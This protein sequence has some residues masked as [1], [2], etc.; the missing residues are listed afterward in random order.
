MHIRLV[1]LVVGLVILVV[2]WYANDKLC[3]DP[4]LKN[5]IRVLIVILGA[6]WALY[7]FGFIA[8]PPI[9]VSS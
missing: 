3:P 6:V 8:G 2:G 5:I 1:P 7:A 4:T 9:T